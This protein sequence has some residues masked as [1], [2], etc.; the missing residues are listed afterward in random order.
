METPVTLTEVLLAEA[1]ATYGVLERLIGQ[2]QDE[3]LP[4]RPAEG[5][6]WMSMGQLL[7][8]CASFGCGKAVRGFV[9]KASSSTT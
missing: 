1:E 9:E 4:W 2:V 6:D 8:H 5:R 7:M 3:E